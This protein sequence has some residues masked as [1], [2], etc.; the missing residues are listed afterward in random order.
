MNVA[1]HW[2]LK[3][4]R[5]RL[6]GGQCP[7]CGEKSF[8]PRPVCPGCGSHLASGR[9]LTVVHLFNQPALPVEPHLRPAIHALVETLPGTPVDL[10]FRSGLPT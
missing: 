5:Y 2:R 8:P 3:A 7:V 10:R 9:A 6:E 4:Q 1:R